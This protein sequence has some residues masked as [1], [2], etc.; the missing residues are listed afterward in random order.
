MKASDI[1]QMEDAE[2]RSKLEDAKEE[3]FNLRIQRA[4]GKLEDLTRMKVLRR[5]IARYLT[6]LRQREIAA[7]LVNRPEEGHAE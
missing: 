6:V 4:A 3:M 1:H 5:D 7:A 2:I